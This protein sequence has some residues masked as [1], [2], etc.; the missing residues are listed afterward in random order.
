MTLASDTPS[1]DPHA[2][3]LIPPLLEQQIAVL[4]DLIRVVMDAGDLQTALHN[5][6]KPFAT[7]TGWC[8]GE[9]WIPDPQ[10]GILCSASV[11]HED[12]AALSEFAAS[13]KKLRFTPGVGVLGCVW[14]SRHAEWI[15]DYQIS[16]PTYA[17]SP[18]RGAVAGLRS[19]FFLPI[20]LQDSVVALLVFFARK[21]R[22]INK[23]LL[24]LIML[25]AAQI[26]L[27]IQRLQ[28]QDAL[29]ALNAQLQQEFAE[30]TQT[31]Q[32]LRASEE[33][34]RQITEH[35]SEVFYIVD[36]ARQQVLYIS[37]SY[38]Q[39]W[40]QS[41]ESLYAD[42]TMFVAAI[43]PDDR[44]RMIAT[45][46][47]QARG[48]ATEEIYRILLRSGTQRWIRDRAF[49]VYTEQGLLYRVAGIAEDITT[50]HNAE[51]QIQRAYETLERRVAER[52]SALSA[53]NA[54][55]ER[56]ARMKDE[57]LSTMSHELRTPLNVILSMTESV[58]EG[59]YGPINERQIRAL[60]AVSESGHHLLVQITDILDLTKMEIGKVELAYEQVEVDAICTASLRMVRHLALA[61]R[62]QIRSS[63]DPMIDL[64]AV[65]P[66]RFTQILVH[67]LSNAIKFTPEGGSVN[68]IVYGNADAEVVCFTV[69]DTGIGI[70]TADIPRLFKPFVQLD[71]SLHR[72]Y[73]GV[74][75]GL[76]L[77]AH[78]AELHR[79]GI[80][81][82]STP[83]QGSRFTVSLPWR[84][85]HAQESAVTT[86]QEVELNARKRPVVLIAEDHDLVLRITSDYLE[87]HGYTVHA[88]RNGVEAVSLAQELLPDV[89]L[90]DIHM[91]VMDGL[92][93]IRHIR[94]HAI[95]AK[96]PIIAITALA[97]A[98]DR[99]RCLSIGASDYLSK[100]VKLSYLVERIEALR[101]STL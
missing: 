64:I 70:A 3:L 33:R 46:P 95:I 15:A 36:L 26:G 66:H 48:E 23:P 1:D 34:F 12:D 84:K 74:G 101:R 98:G 65:D 6:I 35:I 51:Q 81:V 57:F 19:G 8:Y 77:V 85:L 16:T 45:L 13:S 22:P 31:E 18:E 21:P 78:L 87:A 55:L 41:R 59:V 61:K 80:S 10:L 86:H 83:G 50:Q 67:L 28:A 49:P 60:T 93:A 44:S 43:H 97:M 25:V 32:Q 38:E 73:E 89:I 39:I 100:P 37:P 20:V 52:T 24:R 47:R 40:E 54:E 62:L 71:G 27:L 11:W 17:L 14:Q 76:A 72:R 53:A 56:T 30:R 5:L 68:L 63:L 99:E 91:P 88:A 4:L 29:N 2:E 69:E 92:E 82:S 9:V 79:G 75:L 94:T 58:T 42:I 90:M 7:A 96:T